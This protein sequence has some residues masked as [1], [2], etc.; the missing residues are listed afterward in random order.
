MFRRRLFYLVALAL[1]GIGCWLFVTL[2]FGYPG[3]GWNLILTLACW[4]FA[5]GLVCETL[6]NID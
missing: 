4:L 5:I 6:P 1:L 2:L 3:L